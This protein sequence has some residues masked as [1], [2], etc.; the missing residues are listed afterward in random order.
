MTIR[1]EKSNS[2]G[3]F[4]SATFLT[5]F[6]LQPMIFAMC[7]PV[8]QDHLSTMAAALCFFPCFFFPA[9]RAPRGATEYANPSNPEIRKK[10]KKT[11]KLQNPPFRVG[12]QKYRKN[13]E[14]LRKWPFS[15]RFRNFL[16][17]FFCIFGAHPG[18]GDFVIFSY[19]RVTGVFV[20]CSTPG[21]SQPL[22]GIPFFAF[23]R[24]G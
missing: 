7:T 15:D 6:M 20:F 18:M 2:L 17:F 8:K 21:K 11:K 3:N 16:V 1:G 13:T 23:V 19:F 24:Q 14:K 22:R 9:L 12:P 4:R 10:K 5:S